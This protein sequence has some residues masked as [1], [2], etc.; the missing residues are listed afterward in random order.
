M[1]LSIHSSEP[2]VKPKVSEHPT[3]EDSPLTSRKTPHLRVRFHSPPGNS[4]SPQ[5]KIPSE[6]NSPCPP[7]EQRA[8]TLEADCNSPFVSHRIISPLSS[9]SSTNTTG[10]QLRPHSYIE[11]SHR[12]LSSIDHDIRDPRQSWCIIDRLHHHT[13]TTRTPQHPAIHPHLDLRLANGIHKQH[14]LQKSTRSLALQDG[15]FVPYQRPDS[16]MSPTSSTGRHPTPYRRFQKSLQPTK[17]LPQSL[18]QRSR[19]WLANRSPRVS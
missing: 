8:T 18:D 12:D 16:T 4:A 17:N 11:A 7:L 9:R 13:K 14:K 2:S 1:C 6:T 5:P 15:I 19:R 10:R 3:R